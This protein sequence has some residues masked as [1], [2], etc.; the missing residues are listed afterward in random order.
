MRAAY[1]PRYLAANPSLG[2]D[3]TNRTAV[4][5]LLDQLQIQIV[6]DEALL[7]NSSYPANAEDFLVLSDVPQY[8]I[9]SGQASLLSVMGHC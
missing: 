1:L 6:D 7:P 9:I 4:I 2:V 8:G 3:I 5:H